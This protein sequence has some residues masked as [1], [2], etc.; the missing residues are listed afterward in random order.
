MNVFIY[1][2]ISG[3]SI[4]QC[5]WFGRRIREKFESDDDLLEVIGENVDLMVSSPGLGEPIMMY[6]QYLR[7][8]GKLLRI[9]YTDSSGEVAELT[10]HLQ[11]VSLSGESTP[12]IVITPESDKKKLRQQPK[13]EGIALY[14]DQV[15][16]AIP[17]AE[18]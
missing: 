5:A 11:E 12:R 16:Q 18:L 4:D 7:H 8:K 6:R 2:L 9:R 1:S 10:G 13:V 15:I 17:E 3:I 14:L